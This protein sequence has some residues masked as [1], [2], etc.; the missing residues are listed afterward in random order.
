M[1]NV[2]IAVDSA[3]DYGPQ[4]AQ[5]IA[6]ACEEVIGEHRCPVATDVPPGAVTAWVAV[7]HPDD[8]GLSSVRIDFRDRSAAGVLIEQRILTFSTQDSL[9]S[10][11]ISVGSVVAALAGA[12]EG[13]LARKLPSPPPL[14]PVPPVAPPESAPPDWSIDLAAFAAPALEEGPYRLGGLARAHLG[15]YGRPFGVA[16][17]RYAAHPGNPSFSWVS[18]SAGLGTRIGNRAARFNVEFSGEVVFEHTDIRA[19]RGA[20]Q[21]SAGQNGWGGRIGAGA[22]WATMRHVSA[23]FG[24][25]GSLVLPAI[26]V[27]VGG[28][29]A[30]RAPS[31]TLGLLLGIRFQ[32]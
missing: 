2:A 15:F 29:E 21:E 32:P 12:R 18:L 26:R 16:S 7:V 20:D 19:V 24:V 31:A 25:E 5:V 3:T 1:L 17:V 22:V 9:K 13:S 23:I 27:V 14:P 30:T 6:A 11:L 4:A 28:Q 8:R 10:R